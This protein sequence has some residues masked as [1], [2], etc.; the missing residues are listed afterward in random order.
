MPG[1]AATIHLC[2]QFSFCLFLPIAN[3]EF[4]DQITRVPLAKV[5]EQQAYILFYTRQNH[6]ASGSQPVQAVPTSLSTPLS[7][8][9]PSDLGKALTAR[10]LSVRNLNNPRV[11]FCSFVDADLLA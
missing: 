11:I 9:T 4:F 1:S 10:D 6:A 5:L 8:Q 7:A 2:V 3:F